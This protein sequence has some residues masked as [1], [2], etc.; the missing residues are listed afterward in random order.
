MPLL[1]YHKRVFRGLFLNI[2]RQTEED[3]WSIGLKLGSECHLTTYTPLLGIESFEDL[4]DDDRE[5]IMW[6]TGLS[7]INVKSATC[8]HHKHICLKHY[9]TKVT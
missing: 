1:T 7:V 5:I 2:S 4:P 8:P 3:M 9:A 6:G